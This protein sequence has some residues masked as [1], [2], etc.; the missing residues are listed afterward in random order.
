MERDIFSM[1][2]YYSLPLRA[3]LDMYVYN[4]GQANCILVTIDNGAGKNAIFFDTGIQNVTWFNDNSCVRA[5]IVQTLAN[6][7]EQ[8]MDVQFILSYTDRDHINVFPN[9]CQ[10]CLDAGKPIA[11][12][13]VGT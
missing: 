12:V 3:N 2:W 1:S 10:M 13:F 4:V 7:R 6:L 11:T 9:I 5:H 8:I